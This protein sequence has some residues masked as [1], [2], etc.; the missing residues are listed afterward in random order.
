MWKKMCFF[1]DS[2]VSLHT[3]KKLGF[4]FPQSFSFCL[5]LQCFSSPFPVSLVSFL[6]QYNFW[7]V[8]FV[9]P[10]QPLLH[11]DFC[12]LFSFN[13]CLYF[14][15]FYWSFGWSFSKETWNSQH[16]AQLSTVFP[17]TELSS[18]KKNKPNQNQSIIIF[19]NPT[20]PLYKWIWN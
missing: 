19:H 9:L 14:V 4:L 1:A 16:H 7:S 10:Q 15:C 8:R 13:I 5:L 12:I 17:A 6:F 11:F 2:P 20:W 18:W 3:L